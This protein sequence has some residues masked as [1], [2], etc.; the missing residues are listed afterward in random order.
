MLNRDYGVSVNSFLSDLPFLHG[1]C[2]NLA[3]LQ[4]IGKP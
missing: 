1:L 3:R 2:L 4:C